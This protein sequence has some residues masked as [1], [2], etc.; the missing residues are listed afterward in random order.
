MLTDTHRFVHVLVLY[1]LHTIDALGPVAARLSKDPAA[2][3]MVD[4]DELCL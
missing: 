4:E 1:L 3:R 2:S